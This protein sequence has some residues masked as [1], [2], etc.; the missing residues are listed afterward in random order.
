MIYLLCMHDCSHAAQSTGAVTSWKFI[1]DEQLRLSLVQMM[2][3][4]HD[5]MGSARWAEKVQQLD[6]SVRTKLEE[7]C[8]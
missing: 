6:P 3:Y 8:R 7:M 1:A 5:G 2:R 4:L